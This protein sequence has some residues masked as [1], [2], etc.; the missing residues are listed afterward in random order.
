MPELER[1]GLTARVQGNRDTCSIFAVTGVAEFEVGRQSRRRPSRLS[2]EFLIWAGNKASG[3]TG[4]Q[5]MFYKA[6]HG[7]D[8]LG[9]CSDELMPYRSSSDA[10]RRPSP[11]A[12]ANAKE[13][14]RRW[15]V[16]WI[17]RWDVQCP[18]SPPQILAIRQ[19]LAG[20]HP[21][22]CGLRWPKQ[23]HGSELLEVP[24]PKKVFDGHSIML[25]GY[26]R[27]RPAAGRRGIPLPQQRRPEVGQGRLRRDVVRLCPTVC[28]RRLVAPAPVA[29]C[30]SARGAL[31][32]RGDARAGP[33]EVYDQPA[34]H[35]GLGRPAVD[36]WPA[37]LLQGRARRLRGTGLF[38]AEG[39]PLPAA[40]A[41][42]GG[43]RFRHR[44][45]GA[46]RQA[47]G[48]GDGPLLRSRLRRPA[49]WNWARGKCR[50]GQHRL[51]VKAVDKNAASQGFA[52]GLDA[53]DLLSPEK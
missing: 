10:T 52:F 2:E 46:R 3:M 45:R 24:P 6:V 20:G 29:R 35:E 38:R 49:A 22:A 7:L 5:A 30:R 14:S 8:V 18:L 1:L 37:T 47:V 32:G 51:R 28:Q 17:K 48:S 25:T 9:I 27:R 21:V 13:E 12:L 53:L 50:R 31:R 19:A 40:G 4:D 16:H 15:R 44:P 41:G 34:G 42:H 33:P 43:P 11:A 36:P 23:L 26:S 39:R